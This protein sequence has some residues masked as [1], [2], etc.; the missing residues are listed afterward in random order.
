MP[1]RLAGGCQWHGDIGCIMSSHISASSNNDNNP[2]VLLSSC[3]GLQLMWI[4]CMK[5]HVLN[6]TSMHTWTCR[7]AHFSLLNISIILQLLNVH[8]S[9][10]FAFFKF[11]YMS[12]G[13]LSWTIYLVNYRMQLLQLMGW[14]IFPRGR[15]SF[16]RWGRFFPSGGDFSAVNFAPTAILF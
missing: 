1:L 14:Q 16:M 6:C 11:R 5:L 15:S 8:I 9:N 2:H 4:S 13:C 3:I 10:V 12:N 7:V